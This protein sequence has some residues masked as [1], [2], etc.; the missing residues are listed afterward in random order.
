MDCPQRRL[1]FLSTT[2]IIESPIY[3]YEVGRRRLDCKVE[4]TIGRHI[5]YIFYKEVGA[6]VHMEVSVSFA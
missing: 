1:D 5:Q 4:I 2:Y 6:I 3:S